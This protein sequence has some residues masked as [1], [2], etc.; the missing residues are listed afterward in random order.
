MIQVIIENNIWC[1][2]LN[3]KDVAFI[4]YLDDATSFFVDGYKYT[5]AYVSGYWNPKLKQF[6]HWD[7]KKHLLTKNLIFPIGLLNRVTKAIE[8]NNK[9]YEIIDNRAKIV[10][11]EEIEIVGFSPRDYQIDALKSVLLNDRGIIRLATGGGK[12]LIA[13]LVISKFNIPSMIYVIGKDLLYQFHSFLEKTLNQKIGIIGDGKCEIEKFNVCSIWTA[14]KAFDLNTSAS[15][16]DEDWCPEIINMEEEDKEKI[17]KA[18]VDSN[19]AIFDEAHFLATETI[20]SIFKISKSCRYMYGLT[21]SDWRDD[22]A[23]LLLESICGERIYNMPAS[24]LIKRGFL[25]PPHIILYNVPQLKEALPKHY[26]SI[27]KKYIIENDVRNKMIEDCARKAIG[28]GN[29]LLIL[30]RYLSHGEE[31]AKRLNDISLFFVSGEIDGETRLK[32]RAQLEAGELQC[33]IASSVFDI[34]VDIPS[35]DAIILAG[36]GKSTVRTLQRIG[37][38]IRS[39]PG[40]KHAMV[41]DFIDN[42]KYL[43]KHSAI[44]VA[45]YETEKEFKI[46]YMQG[47][48]REGIKKIKKLPKKLIM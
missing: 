4:D 7:G 3:V 48:S 16:D 35:L 41:V 34:G 12:T 46:K 15:L 17:K 26:Q 1:K 5:K 28:Q 37:R 14:I 24:P 25:V 39:F 36:G 21:A 2:L 43:D 20:Q 45:V 10:F 40:K 42:A 22:G 9:E 38:V 23:D 29:K 44:R 27:Y 8:D 31:I 18:I 19:L 6:I 47:A 11:G 32:V 13:S 30:V 33:L